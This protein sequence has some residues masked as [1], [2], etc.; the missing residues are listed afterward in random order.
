MFLG[1]LCCQL[2][3]KCWL[4]P[5]AT[6]P[7]VLCSLASPMSPSF[8]KPIKNIKCHLL[9]NEHDGMKCILFFL[10]HNFRHKLCIRDTDH[11]FYASS[12][13]KDSDSITADLAGLFVL[14]DPI[15]PGLWQVS[16]GQTLGWPKEILYLAAKPVNSNIWEWRHRNLE[17][18]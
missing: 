9:N 11:W 7:F 15:S 13:L 6:L 17:I 3:E 18:G 12:I 16:N 14:C 5:T 8:S 2:M 1:C 4:S 10:P